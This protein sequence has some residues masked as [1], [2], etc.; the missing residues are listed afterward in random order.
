MNRLALILAFCLPSGTLLGTFEL[1]DPATE[2][3]E[4]VQLSLERDE[5]QRREEN[6]L[7]EM[8]EETG[9]CS[10][11]QSETGRIVLLKHEE[12]V[13]LASG[14]FGSDQSVLFSW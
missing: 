7:C 2:I 4:Q 11:I 9:E 10:C 6:V 5:L 13:I 1:T 12:C 8:D 14:P 3:M